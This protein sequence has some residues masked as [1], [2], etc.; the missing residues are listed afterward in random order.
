MSLSMPITRKKIK[1]HWHYGWWMYVALVVAVVVFWNV[2][3]TVTRY[4]TP[5]HLNVEFFAG[6]Q[7]SDAS[8]AAMEELL[9]TVHEELF[10]K[11]EKVSYQFLTM[12]ETYAPV[13]LAV[14]AAAG[15]GDVFLLPAEHFRQMAQNGAL[16]DLQPAI[17][18][19]E[20]RVAGVAL[21]GGM[22]FC[23]ETGVQV[24][25]GIPADSLVG[26]QELGLEGKGHILCVMVTGGNEK[27][28]VSLVDFLV[29]HMQEAS[30]V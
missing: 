3:F 14:W 13:Q 25:Y 17:E 29:I 26:L 5:A 23:E 6:G 20:L 28:A 2:L 1:N 24:Q 11:M 18:K 9:K 30:Q 15:Q 8:A 4:Q 21:S 19:G 12:D 22:V 10:P 16:L 7:H 27:E